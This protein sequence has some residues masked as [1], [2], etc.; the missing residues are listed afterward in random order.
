MLLVAITYVMLVAAIIWGGNR[1]A[2]AH[3]T[4]QAL[5]LAQSSA[6][7]RASL[8]ISE[9]QKY[10]L[11]P[12]VLGEYPDVHTTLASP[13]GATAARL[14]D[15]L[16][17]IAR[18]IGSS[19]LYLL[20][21]NGRTIA[22]S[23]AHLPTSFIGQNYAFRPY[24]TVSREK[25]TAEFFGLGTVSAQPGLYFARAVSDAR[26]SGVIVVKFG[27]DTVERA[28]A[29]AT[30][31]AFVTDAD[32][33]VLI[34]NRPAW[35][36]H[37][38]R[39][40]RPGRLAEMRNTRQFGSAVLS[41][42]RIGP[43]AAELMALESD[44]PAHYARA[45]VAVPV[46]GW[47]LT[48]L[49]PIRPIRSAYLATARLATIA[50]TVFLALPLFLWLRA[51]E[52]AD[53]AA[54]T[55]V[56]LKEQVALRTEE[57]E[58]TQMHFREAREGL[59]HANR[60]GSI[61]QITAAIAHEINQ[62]VSAIRSFS[63]NAGELLR[64]G[65]CERALANLGTISELTARIGAITMELRS[66]ARRGSGELRRTPLEAAIDGALLFTGHKL[67]HAGIVL[68]RDG[69][70]AV[71]VLADPLRLE[72]ILVNLLHNALE[73][74][75]E[76]RP[77]RLLLSVAECGEMVELVLHDTGTG[78]AAEVADTLFTPF[79]TSKPAG[80]GLGL[81]I[82]RDIAREFGGELEV[83]EARPP[84]RTAFRLRLMR[85]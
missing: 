41:P 56:E 31:P 79:T 26:H 71:E 40:L 63:E 66:Y 30:E 48:A 33:V 14:N 23:N 59:A 62:P 7:G 67:R 83:I 43:E 58:R 36:F 32:G 22:A 42:L 69:N 28:W 35:R 77:A 29:S 24:F 34:T 46:A 60:L 65:D 51:R 72:Q 81:G 3:A 19:A 64:Q 16:E 82:A 45:N 68:E 78:I 10:R 39:S 2:S 4:E 75:E 61:G 52:R 25:G 53:L 80:L 20:D 15:K 84:W 74:F 47:T 1:W 49:E 12:I 27:F 70:T 9:L 18:M 50:A 37:T 55:R 21:R 5:R 8:L 17:Q 85:A 6:A 57:L 73:A 54:V 13:G 38:T 76:E 44:E 11:M